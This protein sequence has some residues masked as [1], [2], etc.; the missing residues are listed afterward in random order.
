MLFVLSKEAG[1]QAILHGGDNR[2]Q[3][4]VEQVKVMW[5]LWEVGSSVLVCEEALCSYGRKGYQVPLAC[6]LI[7]FSSLLR[8][9]LTSFFWSIGA[10]VYVLE[11]ISG[12]YTIHL[13]EAPP[14]V[15]LS[16]L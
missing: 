8:R 14:T 3:S 7:T 5:P 12:G 6:R 11:D 4:T 9:H 13:I 10:S 16:R 1:S 15:L 2:T